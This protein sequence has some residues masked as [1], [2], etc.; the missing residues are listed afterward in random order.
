VLSPSNRK[1]AATQPVADDGLFERL[2]GIK[3][4]S[5][6]RS[7]TLRVLHAP[8]KVEEYKAPEEYKSSDNTEFLRADSQV[9]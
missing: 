2:M 5:P 1:R 4:D 9:R 8:D 7:V 3:P 6:N